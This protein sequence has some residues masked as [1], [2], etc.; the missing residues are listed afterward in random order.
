[1]RQGLQLWRKEWGGDFKN[2]K[3]GLVPVGLYGLGLSGL[4]LSLDKVW[5]KYRRVP[6]PCGVR[7]GRVST[8]D[9][10]GPEVGVS[11]WG[12]GELLSVG[13]P[14]VAGD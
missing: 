14:T 8:Q 6:H 12:G 13:S 7:R 2:R 5:F 10:R 9:G 3:R 11:S 1:M 4:L